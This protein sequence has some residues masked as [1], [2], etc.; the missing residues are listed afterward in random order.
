VEAVSV[1]S[2]IGPKSFEESSLDA[3]KQFVFQPPVEDGKPVAMWIKFLVK[4][5]I[6]G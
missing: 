5:R 6:F 2:A 4:F 1:L 3:L